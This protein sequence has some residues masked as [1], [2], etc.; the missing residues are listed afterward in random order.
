MNEEALFAELVRRKAATE[1]LEGFRSYMADSG[2]PDFQLPHVRHL[3]FLAH[4]LERLC[5]GEIDRLMVQM[6]PG[7]AKS[8]VGNVQFLSWYAALFPNDRIL[9]LSATQDLAEEFSRRRR[10]ACYSDEW[11]RISGVGINKDQQGIG[12]FGYG[13]SGSQLAAGVDSSIV[14]R[15]CQLLATDD[16]VTS[17]E[18]ISSQVRRERMFRWYVSEARSR[19]TPGGKELMIGTRWDVDDLMGRII[20]EEGDSWVIIRLP[21]LCDSDEDPLGREIGEPLWPDWFTDRQISENQRDPI[22]WSALYQQVPINEKGAWLAPDA[23]PIVNEAPK[24]LS[25]F[26]AMDLATGSAKSDFSVV[27]IAGL[28]EDRTLYI[29]HV[30]RE[31]A[32][33]EAIV[34]NLITLYKTWKPREILIDNDLGSK[35]FRPLAV[36]IMRKNGTPLPIHEMPTGGRKKE[37]RAAS[38]QGFARMGAVKMVRGPWNAATLLEINYFPRVGSGYYDDQVDCLSLLGRR[39]PMM[40]SGRVEKV[41]EPKP[42]TFALNMSGGKLA[43]TS[44][45]EELFNEQPRNRPNRRI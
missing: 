33:P 21:M 25:I 10:S 38:F 39:M 26:A 20:E 7:S 28:S 29:L 45:L 37:D 42:L 41:V 14:G 6:P 13:T 23:I 30:W 34:E 24:G 15:R 2:H 3:A 16:S 5:R 40:G 36:E 17:L 11:Q 35:M 27:I 43:T 31:R 1:S 32:S 4:H 18:Q 22:M 9:G 44:T 12:H 19:L 8:T